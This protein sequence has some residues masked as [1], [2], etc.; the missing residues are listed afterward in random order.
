M[1]LATTMT[2]RT[3]QVSPGPGV[4]L[5]RWDRLYRT[6]P[7]TSSAGVRDYIHVVDLAKGHI[8]A[9]R[10]LKEQCGCRVGRQRRSEGGEGGEVLDKWGPE[11][12]L[13]HCPPVPV[14]SWAD[15]QPG[16]GH[17]LFGAAD[18][19]G[20]GE[21]LWK[22]GKPSTL[23]YP[24]SLL[25]ADL[26]PHTSLPDGCCLSARCLQAPAQ[27]L[28]FLRAWSAAGW[29]GPG[30][31]QL[32]YDLPFLQIP[33]KVVARREGDVAACYANP[34]LALR[35]LGWTAAL[36]LDRMCEC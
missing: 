30:L 20:H 16:H 14:L 22:E 18:G 17:R 12:W 34:S 19:P 28:C 15:L 27:H 24:A 29:A 36:G 6:F 32:S 4:G 11:W 8:A 26:A 2:Q 3:A 5:K 9:L 33:Y 23:P 35:E 1:S 13:V 10:K 7:P 31:A 21:G 25:A